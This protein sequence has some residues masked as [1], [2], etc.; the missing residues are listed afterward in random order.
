[1]EDYIAILAPTP[2]LIRCELFSIIGPLSIPTTHVLLPDIKDLSLTMHVNTNT[3]CSLLL[4]DSLI[5]PELQHFSLDC[6]I[7]GFT[8]NRFLS[9]LQRASGIQTFSLR[10]VDSPP[11]SAVITTILHAMP[12][13]SSFEFRQCSST[14]PFDILRLLDESTEFLPLLRKLLL[15]T[16]QAVSWEDRCTP[17]LLDGLNSRWEAPSGVTQLADFQFLFSR[18]MSADPFTK[19]DAQICVGVSKLR[20]KGMRIY[21]SQT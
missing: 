5:L 17:L 11:E 12:A 15:Q 8:P 3:N 13:L 21:V 6:R 20:Q 2:R 7:Y 9:F 1:M 10:F 14:T 4:L 18:S 19:L 16:R